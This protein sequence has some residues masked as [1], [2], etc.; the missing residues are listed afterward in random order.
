MAGGP[1]DPSAGPTGDE[2]GFA[3]PALHAEGRGS[4]G[5]TTGPQTDSAGAVILNILL[6]QSAKD[7][8]AITVA[9][10]EPAA[11]CVS[12]MTVHANDGREETRYRDSPPSPG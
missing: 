8:P 5:P 12:F 4:R 7:R 1:Q 2:C 3:V 6:D 10:V 11:H 9:H